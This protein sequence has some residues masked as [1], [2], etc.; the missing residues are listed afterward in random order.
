M[1]KL[2]E[3]DFNARRRVGPDPGD[4]VII[5]KGIR[6]A[7]KKAELRPKIKVSVRTIRAPVWRGVDRIVVTVKASSCQTYR[8]AWLDWAVDPKTKHRPR[9]P[10]AELPRYTDQ[11]AALLRTIRAIVQLHP[12]NYV[13]DLMVDPAV[14]LTEL[15]EYERAR[16]WSGVTS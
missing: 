11:M 3:V 10:E 15:H 16:R 4:I 7:I 12:D 2:I 9:P 13:V 8:R 6:R 14:G 1:G 5:A